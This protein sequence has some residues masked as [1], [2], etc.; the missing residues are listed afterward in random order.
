MKFDFLDQSNCQYLKIVT[1]RWG[2]ENRWTYGT[3]SGPPS[4]IKHQ[5]DPCPQTNPATTCPSASSTAIN[6]Y[7][8]YRAIIVE[9]CQASGTHTLTCID[10]YGD[11][12][13]GGYIEISDTSTPFTPISTL[14]RTVQTTKYCEKYI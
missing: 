8:S 13:H 2:S 11:G 6:Y 14:V 12:W 1:T 5:V 10:S 3:C 4:T 9:C 7:S